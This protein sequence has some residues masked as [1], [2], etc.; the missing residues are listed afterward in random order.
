MIVKSLRNR[1]SDEG[2]FLFFSLAVQGG[3]ERSLRKGIWVN[4]TRKDDMDHSTLTVWIVD[5][6]RQYCTTVLDCLRGSER[7]RLAEQ[8]HRCDDFLVALRSTK[9]PPDVVLLDIQLPDMNGVDAIPAARRILPRLKILLLTAFDNEAYVVGAL[10]RGADGYLLKACST[11]ELTNAVECVHAGYSVYDEKVRDHIW[12]IA[13]LS[14]PPMTD[15][16]LS[17]RE[18]E[19]LTYVTRGLTVAKIANEMSLSIDTVRSHLKSIHLKLDVHTRGELV[20]K[21]LKDKLL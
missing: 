8:Y 14:E 1:H 5:D 13:R 19:T 7:I 9:V 10:H 16:N 2:G 6:S 3:H 12:K 11:R 18:R 20:A 17:I 4:P 15:R 21:I